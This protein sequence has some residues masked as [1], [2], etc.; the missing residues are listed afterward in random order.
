MK[1]LAI[2]LGTQCGWAISPLESG[3]GDLSNRKRRSGYGMV[4]LRFRSALDQVLGLVDLVVYEEVRRHMGVTAAHRYGGLEAILTEECESRELNYE[5]VPVADI[6]RM[7]TGK[8]NS[9][10]DKMIEAAELKWP[11]IEIV[12]DNH[13]DALWLL[14]FAHNEYGDIDGK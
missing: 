13:A 9:K 14:A 11:N 1:I 3:T 12:D 4:Y 7:A 8:G 10:K 2:D 5:S 6:K